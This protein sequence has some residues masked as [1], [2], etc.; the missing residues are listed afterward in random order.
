MDEKDEK[1]MLSKSKRCV[2]GSR[3][4]VA[5]K[6]TDVV[7]PIAEGNFGKRITTLQFKKFLGY[8]SETPN[9]REAALKAHLHPPDVFRQIYTNK[10]WEAQFRAAY[11]Y[12]IVTLEDEA[13]RRAVKGVEKPVFYKDKQIGTEIKYS[14][15]LLMFLLKSFDNTR[16]GDRI[17]VISSDKSMSP[18]KEIILKADKKSL[19]ELKKLAKKVFPGEG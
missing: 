1:I 17:D 10:A 8:L 3:E 7:I 9:L 2:K 16:F 14:D 12:V 15:S 11:K 13:I 19:A 18:P 4:Y 5:N 6:V